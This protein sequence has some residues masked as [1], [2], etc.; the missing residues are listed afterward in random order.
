[1][2]KSQIYGILN[3]AY[4]S[5]NHHE[6]EA[7]AHLGE[8]LQGARSFVDVGASLGQYTARVN[9]LLRGSRLVAVEADPVRHE[10]LAR[11]CAKWS[12][13]TG[14]SIEAV[15]A[16]ATEVDGD[17]AF[18]VTHSN[19]SGGLFPHEVTSQKVQWQE[20]RVPARTLDSLCGDLKPDLVKIDVEGGELRV[21]QGAVGIL[22]E[23]KAKFL[24]EVHGWGDLQSGSAPR[25]VYAFMRRHGYHNA[26]FHGQRVFMRMSPSLLRFKVTGLLR[27]ARRVLLQRLG[28]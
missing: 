24:V 23:G 1:M 19:V 13:Q 8:L 11:N 12:A 28:L 5:A 17:V 4:F 26:R 16:A 15:F 10:E 22:R 20:M 2:E 18:Y 3:E 21:L 9:E 25:D 27:D 14:N 7:L 6:K